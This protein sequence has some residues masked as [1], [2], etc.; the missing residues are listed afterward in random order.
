MDILG[1]GHVKKQIPGLCP[2]ECLGTQS[3][4]K[5]D[6]MSFPLTKKVI[7]ASV[8][9]K[10]C[11]TGKND[12][13]N[14]FEQQRTIRKA[15]NPF[16]K[17]I[18]EFLEEFQERF[19]ERLESLDDISEFKERN[20]YATKENKK[21]NQRRNKERKEST[22]KASSD[23]PSS[24]KG[25]PDNSPRATSPRATEFEEGRAGSKQYGPA[26]AEEPLADRRMDEP[27]V[28]QMLMRIC[29]RMVVVI[30]GQT[31]PVKAIHTVDGEIRI[32]VLD[33][34]T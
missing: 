2:E 21:D 28:M 24:D 18:A 1:L 15:L 19:R 34:D 7:S 23:K 20:K 16:E 32:Q 29:H 13:F 30:D 22:D 10:V 6:P 8:V 14:Y 25:S 27:D 4:S 33:Y 9:R 3:G 26:A 31:V 12:A 17:Q 5:K 11:G